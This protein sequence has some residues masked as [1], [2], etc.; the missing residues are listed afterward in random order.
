MVL[1]RAVAD[2][3]VCRHYRIGGDSVDRKANL[4]ERGRVVTA[5]IDK[6]RAAGLVVLGDA[7]GFKAPRKW[8][9]TGPGRDELGS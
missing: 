8:M 1:L 6:L 2:G 3:Y 9:L 4:F 5:A 7:D